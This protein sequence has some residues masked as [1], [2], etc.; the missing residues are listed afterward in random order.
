MKINRI[1]RLKNKATVTA[2]AA[3]L[4]GIASGVISVGNLLGWWSVSFDQ[5]R[6]T[7]TVTAWI[8]LVF[9][10]VGGIVGTIT[11]P[12]TVGMGDSKQAQGYTEPK[13]DTDEQA[14]AQTAAAKEK[15]TAQE[16]A[17]DAIKVQTEALE[18]K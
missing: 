2:L 6:A 15:P 4:I 9:T 16:T 1:L 3:L 18:Q 12:T 11:D 8:G 7:T 14:K 13:K 5:E 17:Q 10:L